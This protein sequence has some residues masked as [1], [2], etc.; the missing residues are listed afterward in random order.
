MQYEKEEWYIQ[1]YMGMGKK[2]NI[3]KTFHEQYGKNVAIC[4]DYWKI[5]S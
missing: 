1:Q 4:W 3:L 2:Q 5:Y